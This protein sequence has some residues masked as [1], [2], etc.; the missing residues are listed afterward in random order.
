MGYGE[1]GAKPKCWIDVGLEECVKGRGR[2]GMWARRWGGSGVD[3]LEV[4]RCVSATDESSFLS[5]RVLYW[6][7]RDAWMLWVVSLVVRG[8]ERSSFGDGGRRA[9][10]RHI[11]SCFSHIPASS[12]G[13]PTAPHIKFDRIELFETPDKCP[14]G[15]GCAS[16]LSGQE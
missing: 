14:W 5:M 6:I 1:G 10:T 16:L 12:A 15:K 7:G 8:R 4:S 3:K 9:V 2:G 13:H 11:Y